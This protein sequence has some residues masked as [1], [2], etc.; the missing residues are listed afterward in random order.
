MGLYVYTRTP[1]PFLPESE[2]G[3]L[4]D[5]LIGAHI[6]RSVA[7]ARLPVQ[8]ARPGC[9]HPV[10]VRPRVDAGRTRGQAV[11]FRIFINKQ[12]VPRDVVELIGQG[13]E[14]GNRRYVGIEEK[15]DDG[16]SFEDK[17]KELTT[18][19]KA[20]MEEGERLDEEI[21]KNLEGIGFGF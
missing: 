1:G 20:Q 6:N 18:K 11:V 19:L 17:M 15:E 14:R 10:L 21:K 4:V 12:R 16:I 9:C 5:A 7:D 3:A 8:V 2:D 13:I